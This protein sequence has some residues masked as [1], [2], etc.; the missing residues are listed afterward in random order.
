MPSQSRS[1]RDEKRFRG[2][3]MFA[4][5]HILLYSIFSIVVVIPFWQIFKK[6]GFNPYLSIFVV[7]PILNLLTLYYIAFSNWRAAG[8]A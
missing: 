5:T 2:G 8:P 7:V 4:G 3:N 6:A 1:G